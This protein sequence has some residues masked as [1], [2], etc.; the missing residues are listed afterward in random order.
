MPEPDA[1]LNI[2]ATRVRRWQ[3][4]FYVHSPPS[5]PSLMSARVMTK[6]LDIF[7]LGELL[8]KSPE[9]IRKNMRINPS[10]V[11]PRM[12]IPGTKILRWRPVEVNNWLVEQAGLDG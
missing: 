2:V 12:H 11:P 9:T 3:R 6:Y 10:R 4:T 7:E 8:G 5:P 1:K